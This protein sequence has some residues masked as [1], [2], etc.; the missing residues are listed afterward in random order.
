[1]L[2]LFRI[3]PFPHS[4]PK[5]V[6]WVYGGEVECPPFLV[7]DG[8]RAPLISLMM[9]AL[10]SGLSLGKLHQDLPHWEQN[11]PNW[12]HSCLRAYHTSSFCSLPEYRRKFLDSIY[13]N[14][15]WG[16]F[17]R[18]EM[19]CFAL[20]GPPWQSP[21][22]TQRSPGRHQDTHT[23]SHQF[24]QHSPPLSSQFLREREGPSILS[25][26]LELASSKSSVFFPGT[27]SLT[28]QLKCQKGCPLYITEKTTS[29]S[30]LYL[31]PS[32][33]CVHWS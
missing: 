30:D 32:S 22:R 7:W 8:Q 33:W 25:S 14:R 3:F 26:S 18:A 4:I 2:D 16:R 31:R 17:W 29:I 19:G 23:R 1:M 27:Y 15:S 10:Y 11:K 24:P 20:A 6:I 9:P 21:P 5:D 13:I 28:I 12:K